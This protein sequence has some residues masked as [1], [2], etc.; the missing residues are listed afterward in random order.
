[1]ESLNIRLEIL[2]SDVGYV[3]LEG[4]MDISGVQLVSLKFTVYTAT[5]KKPVIVDLSQVEMITSIGLRMLLESANALR[6]HGMPMILLNPKQNVEN[7]LRLANIDQILPIEYELD[8]AL[9]KIC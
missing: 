5:R 3:H 9:K 6:L 8:S 4:R 1:M 7:V 2:D